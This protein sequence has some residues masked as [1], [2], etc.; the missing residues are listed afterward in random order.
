[1]KTFTFKEQDAI[2]KMGEA[3]FRRHFPC[4]VEHNTNVYDFIL[5][6]HPD[7]TF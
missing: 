3:L 4:F 7:I 5:R 2:G 6:G 1:M